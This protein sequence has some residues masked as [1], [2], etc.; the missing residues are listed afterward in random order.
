MWN[1]Q[2]DSRKQLEQRMPYTRRERIII[3]G[4]PIKLWEARDAS[5]RKLIDHVR[6]VPARPHRILPLSLFECPTSGPHPRIHPQHLPGTGTDLP[7]RPAPRSPPRSRQPTGLAF[8]GTE[9]RT[10][11]LNRLHHRG[12][13]NG[14]IGLRECSENQ[15]RHPPQRGQKSQAT[16]FS[17]FPLIR[18]L[19][20]TWVPR[21]QMRRLQRCGAG[22]YSGVPVDGGKR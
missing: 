21:V 11:L 17:M 16:M 22:P 1:S 7:P 4:H 6:P 14:P 9:P 2:H 8:R 20:C 13:P 18:G 12:A 15:K 3:L 19:G 10:L 5:C